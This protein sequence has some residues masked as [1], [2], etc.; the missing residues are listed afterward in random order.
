MNFKMK[1]VPVLVLMSFVVFSCDDYLDINENPNFPTDA[2]IEGLMTR[3]T[4]ESARNTN[5]VAGTVSFFTQHF[6]SPNAATSTD[7][8]QA[9]SYGV[10]WSSLYSV[11]GDLAEMEI[12]ADRLDAP[13][14]GG[15]GKILKA[16]NL[17][18]LTSMFGDA[19]YSQALFAQ[20]LNP[21]YD[22]SEDIY[23]VMLDLLDEAIADLQQPSSAVVPAGDDYIFNGN[24]QAWI[25]TAYALKARY[26]NH[27]SKLGAAYNTT[28]ILAAVDNAFENSNQDFQ[29]NFFE[30]QGTGAENPWY[31]LAVN[32]AGLLLGGW[33]SE[34]FV[35]QLNGETFGIVD[36][37]IEFITQPVTRPGDP[38]EGQYIGTRNG[39]G[40][41]A[42]P[43]QNVRAVLAV[44][45]WYANAP[46]DP[47][48]MATYAEM[49]FIE[50][51][52][53]LAAQQP[54]RAATAYEEG[55]RAHMTKLGVDP[56]DI[57]A[58]W[59]NPEVSTNIDLDKIMKEKYVAM[60]L[61]PEKWNDARRYDYAYEGFQIPANHNT[62]L[63]GQMI[64]LVRY[65]DS[66]RQRNA[67]QIPDRGAPDPDQLLGR[68]FWD[69]P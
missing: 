62:A 6:A 60:F 54:G 49:K 43:E 46:T 14:Y 37:R 68:I 40:R 42:D 45:S 52:A 69:T 29:M 11:L 28:A 20:T 7:T 18:L 64:R 1:Y 47:L 35:N 8:H 22:S 24:R 2:P 33:L 66:E 50:A 39:A 44:G 19:P 23:G 36:P 61:I 21:P 31:R 63:N 12:K 4:L 13:W 57:D 30:G 10:A 3:T 55:I 53:A 56:G 25:R 15:I 59:A 27:Y 38:R 26:L 16:Y 32:N 9:V 51:E 65:P 5:R 17:G 67:Q 34:H 58:Y 48:Q 41:G